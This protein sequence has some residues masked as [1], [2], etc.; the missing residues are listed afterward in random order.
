MSRDLPVRY[1]NHRGE[2]RVRRI[3]P[4]GVRFGATKW[5]PQPQWLLKCLDVEKG[6]E[7][8]FGLMDCD[9]TVTEGTDAS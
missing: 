8:E 2:T 3:V 4:L 6:Q 5:H 7:R 1:T 9:F